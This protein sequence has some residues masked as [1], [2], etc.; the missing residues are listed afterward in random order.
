MT[1]SVFKGMNDMYAIPGEFIW[2]RGE[3]RRLTLTPGES[4]LELEVKAVL[5]PSTPK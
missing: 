3:F 2:R 1:R 4:S 5:T